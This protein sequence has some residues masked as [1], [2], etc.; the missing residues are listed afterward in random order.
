MPTGTPVQ[1]AIDDEHCRAICDEIGDR[2]RDLLKMNASELPSKLSRLLARLEEQD[3]QA[4]SLVPSLEDMSWQGATG[5]HPAP[6]S[7]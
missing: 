1:L 6:H 2:L 5:I 7:S 3:R 4:P